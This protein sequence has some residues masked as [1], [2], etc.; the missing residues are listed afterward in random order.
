MHSKKNILIILLISL[1]L[2]S[3]GSQVLAEPAE[4]CEKLKE[5]HILLKEKDSLLEKEYM[6]CKVMPPSQEKIDCIEKIEK[7]NKKLD[8]ETDKIIS[9]LDSCL[10]EV[11]K[12]ERSL[13]NSI[14]YLAVKI[15]KTELEIRATE[16]EI[17]LINLDITQTEDDIK[18]TEEN[19][20]STENKIEETKEKLADGIRNLYEYDNQNLV[21]LTLAEG[22]LSDFFDEIVYIE[23]FQ[24]EIE[25]NL[26]KLKV[27][28]KNLEEKKIGLK[29][30]KDGLSK[31]KEEVASKIDDFNKTI[32]HHD[33]LK[34]ETEI[35]L[36]ITQG[37]E[38][39]YK[40]LL[41]K[42]E[43]QKKQ[44][45]GDIAFLAS[46]KSAEIA[47]LSQI[48]G[49]PTGV[50]S[51]LSWYYNQQNYSNTTI[52]FCYNYNGSKCT[53]AQY[54]CAITS[55]AMV[56]TKH[57][58]TITPPALKE[59]AAFAKGGL[60]HWPPQSS[61]ENITLYKNTGHGGVNW[62]E[63]DQEISQ[64]N[65]V[66]IFINAQNGAGHYVVIH[67]KITLPAGE[68]KYVVHDPYFKPNIY[69]DESLAS[70]GILYY[71]NP[72]ALSISNINQAIIY[73]PQKNL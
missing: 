24:K 65:P 66:I 64:G 25:K 35:V 33:N 67:S 2:I 59:E 53:L 62:E 48:Y 28:K 31:R 60:L 16:Q 55:V 21:K 4:D 14:N 46:Q 70:L 19:I 51:T 45:L 34:Q 56:F 6:K 26:D 43:E 17:N 50:D 12:R 63:I 18:K 68:Q 1:A 69:L 40:N 61:D 22:S 7:E 41:A 29:K 38:E 57:G 3:A 52:P 37:D 30:Q 9:K 20:K 5:E 44:I 13:K 11:L 42:L 36:D 49:R 71:D 15:E 8:T 72:N 54:G 58:S 32:T 47:K 73:H 23:N 10:G 39:T 27:D